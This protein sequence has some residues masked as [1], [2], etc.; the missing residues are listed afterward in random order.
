MGMILKFAST[1][2]SECNSQIKLSLDQCIFSDKNLKLILDDV[3]Q[4]SADYCCKLGFCDKTTNSNIAC[5]KKCGRDLTKLFYNRLAFLKLNKD[6]KIQ[7]SMKSS[8]E[9]CFSENCENGDK[10]QISYWKIEGIQKSYNSC[11]EEYLQFTR[12]RYVTVCQNICC[13]GESCDVNVLSNFK[14]S[15]TQNANSQ[16]SHST[17]RKKNHC[18]TTCFENFRTLLQKSYRKMVSIKIKK[19]YLSQQ[20]IALDHKYIGISNQNTAFDNYSEDVNE[21][22]NMKTKRNLSKSID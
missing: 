7:S 14:N 4:K 6:S 2:W 3:N 18:V 21:T 16:Y 17:D 19:K 1:I 12:N 15:N 13:Q 22:I 9:K 20:L 10:C 11:I 8:V 5:R